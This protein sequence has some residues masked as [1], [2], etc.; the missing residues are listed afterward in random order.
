[1]LLA[2]LA[3]SPADF[4][5]IWYFTRTE[6]L[7]RDDGLAVWKWDPNVKPHVTDTNNA[8]DGDMLIAYALALA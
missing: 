4:E 7:L 1:M 2:Y 3:A 5:Q 8:S 6:L